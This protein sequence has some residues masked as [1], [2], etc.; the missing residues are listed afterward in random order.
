MVL[1]L[2]PVARRQ[3]RSLQR[4]IAKESYPSRAEKYI[5]RL[6]NALQRISRA[7]YQGTKRDDLGPGLRIVGFERRV[8]ILFLPSDE[9]VTVI[10]IFYAGRQPGSRDQ[11]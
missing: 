6:T 11:D 4:Y 8:S 5:A 7:P 3:L 10:G 9:Q 2:T 1:I